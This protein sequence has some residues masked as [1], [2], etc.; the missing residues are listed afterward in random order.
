MRKKFVILI[1][2]AV[3]LSVGLYYI[4]KI[5]SEEKVSSEAAPQSDLNKAKVESVS[6]LNIQ[7]QSEDSKSQEANIETKNVEKYIEDFDKAKNYF[8]NGVYF[9]VSCEYGY[10][11]LDFSVKEDDQY[12]KIKLTPDEFEKLI[13]TEFLLKE[14]KPNTANHLLTSGPY[15]YWETPSKI[16]YISNDKTVVQIINLLSEYEGFC[17]GQGSDGNYSSASV[18]I[19]SIA[20]PYITLRDSS[21]GYGGG[22][23]P[24]AGTS[25]NLLNIENY[26]VNKK[27]T[28]G[29]PNSQ[30]DQKVNLFDW[31]NEQNILLALKANSDLKEKIG[32]ELDSA[33]NIEEVLSMMQ[34]KYDS[35]E[36]SI[37]SDKLSA[38]QQIAIYDYD[39][40]KNLL[41][42]VAGF[43][44]GCE[45]M[46]GNYTEFKL[47]LQPKDD[48]KKILQLELDSAKEQGRNPYFMR[49]LH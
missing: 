32:S 19:L 20:G 48:F 12:V 4:L 31:A 21:S 27:L 6:S 49:F 22:M 7:N 10:Y 43:G 37:P 24:Y 14:A 35:C 28:G 33:K 9:D 25:I 17:S 1:L 3:I 44:Y 26:Q 16:S 29:G 5:R 15:S 38:F 34:T 42:V 40:N 46:H 23:H 30:R 41:T 13:N 36:I 45:V 8:S 18:E 11:N 2:L 47:S 39:S